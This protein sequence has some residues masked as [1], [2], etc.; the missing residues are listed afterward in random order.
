[1]IRCEWANGD[2]LMERY[3]DEEWGT[4]V[5]DDRKLFEYIVLD[6]AQAGLSWMTVLRKRAGYGAAFQGF[7]PALVAAFDDGDVARL[8][9]DSAIVR[10][11]QKITSAITNA[12]RFLEV[13]AEFGSFD[14]YIWRFV[15]GAT[16]RNAWTDM[17]RIPAVSPESEAMSRDLVRRGFRFVGPTICYAFMQAAGLVNDHTTD[18]F[19]YDR[20]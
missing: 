9:Q 11:R 20:L 7:D 17:R 6:G 1:M 19:R 16:I 13:Q 4:P 12:R 5:H 15:G 18:C 10:N 14:A 2:A 8:M 3:H